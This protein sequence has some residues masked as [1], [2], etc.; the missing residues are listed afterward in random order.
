MKEL[1]ILKIPKIKV[2]K[3]EKKE[4]VTKKKKKS[5]KNGVLIFL[6]SIGII[7]ASAILAFA[8]YII[9]T[10]PDF[11]VEELYTKEPTVLYDINGDEMARIGNENV[12]LVTYSDLPQVLVDALIA[13]ED[14]RFFQHNGFD[15]ARFIKASLGQLAG[16]DAGGASTLS[17]QVIKNTY[18]DASLTSG[19]KGIIRKFTDIYMAVFKLEAS[20]TKEEIIEFYLNSQWLGGGST[21][22]ASINGVEQGS[23]YFFGKSV[24]D[25]TL[26]EASLLV[27][28]FNAPDAYNP[29]NNPDLASQRRSTV[30]SLMVRHGYITESEKEFAESVPVQSLLADHTTSEDN[31]M[32][33]AF[34]DYTL[35]KV[36]EETGDNPYTTPMEIYTTLD[37]SIQE[38]LYLLETGELYTF[39]T[40]K[41]Q[42]GMAVTSTKDGSVLALSGGRNYQVQ[43]TNRAVGKE[44]RGIANQPGSAAKIIFDYGPYIEY[45]NGST[46][47]LFLD[48]P[49]S[50]TT[51]GSVVN[52]DRTYWG[53]ITMRRALVNSRNVPAIQAFQQVASEVG[54]DKI[55]EFAHN[56]G[57]DFGENLYESAGLGGFDGT[58][59]LS[60]SAAYAAFGRGGIY[61]EPYTFTR[62]VYTE[63]EEEYTHPIEQERV[64]SEETAYMI[65]DILVDAGAGGIGGSIH[66]NGTDVAAKGGTSTIDS[67]SAAALGIPRSA[68]PNHWNITYSPDYS[69]ALWFGYDRLTEGYLT[70]GTGYNPRRQIMAAVAK[71]IYKTGSR[72]EQPSGVVSATIELGTY[73]LQLASEYTPSNLKSTELFKAGYEPTEVSTRF[74]KLENPT[75]GKSTYDG[76][77]IRISWDAIDTPDA[78]DPNYL[79]DYFNGYFSDYY[80]EYAQQFYNNRISYNN[81]YIGTIGYQVY[82]QDTS[83]NLISLG[84]TTNNNFTYSASPGTNYTF[85]VK[86][87][88]S[89]FK[90][91]MS[92]GLT[93]NVQTNMDS[94]VGDMVDPSNPNN[95]NN[96]GGNNNDNNN[97]TN[98]NDPTTD[99]G[100]E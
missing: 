83:G 55:A 60:M 22:Y 43:G 75:N 91:N 68:T 28:M 5:V 21:N 33:Q 2:K 97:T 94:N 17:M 86:S 8:L 90:D 4:K 73:P 96:N 16:Q 85:V 67:E 88:Y 1:V 45:L 62:I 76:S 100:L 72:F 32:Y 69:I 30:L 74:S 78:I 46:G 11:V 15:A 70:S 63:S 98:P 89:I 51:G 20:Y 49:W 25:L 7:I 39:A 84:F 44:Y 99:T 56:L 31:D 79:A 23:Q 71:R 65:T 47:T 29:Y 14:S 57:I 36:Q 61:I 80:S 48:N 19:I 59:P 9:I 64:M 81:S 6:I 77:T 42:F 54:A 34:I 58:N 53:E 82:L 35:L 92:S 66:I 40:E 52:S 95:G 38:T 41:V 87:A 50:Y 26:A 13:T 12:E 27:G 18:T 3:K 10:S 37:P 24:S 93:I